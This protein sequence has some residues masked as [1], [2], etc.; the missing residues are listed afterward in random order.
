MR[1]ILVLLIILCPLLTFSQEVDGKAPENSTLSPIV[2]N[3]QQSLVVDVDDP[4]KKFEQQRKVGKFAQII[5][6]AVLSTSVYLLAKYRDEDINANRN[7]EPKK[8]PSELV[9]AGGTF[10]VVGLWIDI[11]AGRHLR[12]K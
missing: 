4:F 6:A 1:H 2:I 9:I 3:K 11:D 10:L 12:K 7:Y 5:G 8:V